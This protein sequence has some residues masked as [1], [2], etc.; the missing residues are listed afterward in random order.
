MDDFDPFA[1]ARA[2]VDEGA[3]LY[4]RRRAVGE[5]AEPLA[6]IANRYL[7][8]RR[9]FKPRTVEEIEAFDDSQAELLDRM[10][11]T[12]AVLLDDV[13]A[14]LEVIGEEIWDRVDGDEEQYEP[15]DR[16]V[17]TLADDFRRILG[18]TTAYRFDRRLWVESA[19]RAGMDPIAMVYLVPIEDG[20]RKGDYR[21]DE[22]RRRLGEDP[23]HLDSLYQPPQPS[24]GEWHAIFDELVRR[25]RADYYTVPV[26][27]A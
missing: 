19:I 9:E 15:A 22:T 6:A 26:K 13:I 5:P 10:E 8:R 20:P 3:E 7:E 2:D 23:A 1:A 11:D 12:P 24:R 4:I 14:K 17:L 27:S 21:E 18:A 16:L 25:G